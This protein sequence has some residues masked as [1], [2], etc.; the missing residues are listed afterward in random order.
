MREFV[1]QRTLHNQNNND[2]EFEKDKD[3]KPLLDNYPHQLIILGRS[4]KKYNLPEEFTD[5]FK[6]KLHLLFIP[7]EDLMDDNQLE[8][9]LE[10]TKPVYIER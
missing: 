7:K 8:E 2:I 5:E 6:N 3:Y 10:S 4:G 1:C 9:L